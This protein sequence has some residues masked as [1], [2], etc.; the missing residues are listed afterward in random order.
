MQW[1]A[2]KKE[3]V[4]FQEIWQALFSPRRHLPLL[5]RHLNANFM[6]GDLLSLSSTSCVPP[7]N[8]AIFMAPSCLHTSFPQQAN[9]DLLSV[10]LLSPN[11][12]NSSM[13]LGGRSYFLFGTILSDFHCCAGG[14]LA[15][16]RRRK[17]PISSHRRVTTG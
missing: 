6:P 13:Q 8:F 1:G 3:M 5:I 2:I 17:K 7:C 14:A 16:L 4:R 11:A 10:C 12:S 15:E 9:L